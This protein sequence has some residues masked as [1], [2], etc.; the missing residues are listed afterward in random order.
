MICIYLCMPQYGRYGYLWACCCSST[1][2]LL[3]QHHPLSSNIPWPPALTSQLYACIINPYSIDTK[4]IIYTILGNYV[5][6]TITAIHLTKTT[7]ASWELV[8]ILIANWID[9]CRAS[10][11]LQSTSSI[12]WM[13]MLVMTSETIIYWI[14]IYNYKFWCKTKLS[15]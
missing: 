8:A 3:H 6:C 7:Y 2:S 10:H 14:K 1:N 5:I 12:D 11:V 4:Y 9:F 13:L 15:H